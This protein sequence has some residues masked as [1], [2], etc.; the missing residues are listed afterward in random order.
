MARSDLPLILVDNTN[1]LSIL[2]EGEYKFTNLTFEEA[3][4]IIDMHDD[5]DV[6]KFFSGYELKQ[7]VFNYLN[8]TDRDFK[9]EPITDMKVGQDAIT[10]KLYRTPSE[11]QPVLKTANGI[12]A[13]KIENVYVTCQY[14]FRL[15]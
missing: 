3:K 10:F 14:F 4:A 7:V 12:E 13:K 2:N 9:Y 8:V 15:K 1:I 6:I 5:D 11:T